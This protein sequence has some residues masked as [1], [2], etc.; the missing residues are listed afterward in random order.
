MKKKIL[1]STLTQVMSKDKKEKMVDQ[2]SRMIRTASQQHVT[3]SCGEE[4]EEDE[5]ED[6]YF[7]ADMEGS[8]NIVNL[9]RL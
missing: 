4:E 3:P 2:S 5:E 1:T 8:S 9:L 6:D 7:D